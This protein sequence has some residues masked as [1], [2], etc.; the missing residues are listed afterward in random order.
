MAIF[1]DPLLKLKIADI[2]LLNDGAFEHPMPQLSTAS[3]TLCFWFHMSENSG[4]KIIV[5]HANK[6]ITQTGWTVY[7]QNLNLNFRANLD[8]KECKQLT[9]SVEKTAGWQHFAVTISQETKT[10]TA[11]LNGSSDG[12]RQQSPEELVESG[13]V[14]NNQNLIIGGYTDTAGG[15]FNFR[16]GESK[17]ELVDDLRLYPRTFAEQEIKGFLST[18]DTPIKAAFRAHQDLTTNIVYFNANA[19]EGKNLSYLW[20]F[21]DGTGAL[22]EKVEHSYAYCAEFEVTLRIFDEAHKE[23]TATSILGFEGETILPSKVPVFVNNNEG[24]ACY[25]IPAIVKAANGDLIAF[26]EGRLQGCSDATQVIHI[27]AK[28]SKDNGESWLPLEVVARNFINGDEYAC[29]NP[30]PVVDSI[31]GT[32]KI[33]LVFSK[34][35]TSEW[36]ISKGEGITRVCCLSSYDHGETWGEEQDITLQVHKPYNP[37]YVSIYKDAAHPENKDFDWRKQVPTLGHA[38][39]LKGS[40]KK[41][42][43][44]GRFFYIGVRSEGD[45]SVFYTQNYAFWSDDLGKT[46]TL[47]DTITLREDGS[48]AKGLNEATAVELSDGSVLINS[49]NYQDGKLV[50]TRAVTLGTFDLKGQLNF[51]KVRHDSALIDS[52][53]QASII[54]FPNASNDVLL[55]ANP[56]HKKARKMITLKLSRDAGKTWSQKKLI[57]PGPSAYS[58]LVILQNRDIGLLYEQGNHGGIVFSRLT[59]ETLE[60]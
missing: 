47:G 13:S 49:R 2:G 60:L 27:V 26:A 12:W 22:G 5:N 19:S 23:A 38:I 11:F 14:D 36:A 48:S 15:H 32:G 58:D 7:L 34:M 46:W 33:V 40:N 57:D 52:G 35:E 42:S 8:G 1:N 53:V 55:F 51:G 39:Q 56:D 59:K 3:Y 10:I 21:G 9:T 17:T 43:T 28:R 25:R 41:T 20:N 18:N 31:K 54:K 30:S 6:T 44:Q 16:F 45:D 50:G 37:S 24:Y 4:L 29:M